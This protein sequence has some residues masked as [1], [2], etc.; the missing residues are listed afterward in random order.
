MNRF[1]AALAQVNCFMGGYSAELGNDDQ[2][3]DP[4]TKHVN[5]LAGRSA[6]EVPRQPTSAQVE[7][8]VAQAIDSASKKV[9]AYLEDEANQKFP[10][11]EYTDT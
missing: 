5:F 8:A 2:P 11:D 4:V 9:I 6:R 1:D 10:M 3:E 7:N